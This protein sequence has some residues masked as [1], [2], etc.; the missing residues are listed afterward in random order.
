[1]DT[2]RVDGVKAPQHFKTRRSHFG[3][4]APLL[5]LGRT[6]FSVDSGSLLLRFVSF[7]VMSLNFPLELIDDLELRVL[8]VLESRRLRATSSHDP[9]K[10]PPTT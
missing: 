5:G 10:K 4:A 9:K 6:F 7:Q 2:S 3:L 8:L 1:M